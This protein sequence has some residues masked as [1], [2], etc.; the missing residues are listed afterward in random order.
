M[1]TMVL[2][3]ML[4]NG[5]T[6]EFS[7]VN[8]TSFNDCDNEFQKLVYSKS[9]TNY[10]HRKQIGTFYKGKEVFMYTCIWIKN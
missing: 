3:I 1:Q 9:I 10:K 5:T 4:M 7:K 2:L 6:L 8:S